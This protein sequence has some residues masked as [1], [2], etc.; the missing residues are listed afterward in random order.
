M[1]T[2]AEKIVQNPTTIGMYLRWYLHVLIGGHAHV[3]P[4]INT[5]DAWTAVY[6]PFTYFPSL[7]L[8]HRHLGSYKL[9]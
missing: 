7:E 6:E 2:V 8:Q 1:S 5:T 3:Q 9:N 4:C